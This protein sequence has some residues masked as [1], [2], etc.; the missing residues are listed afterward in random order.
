MTTKPRSEPRREVGRAPQPG[1][2][3]PERE[4]PRD[5][6]TDAP[7]HSDQRT[8]ENPLF[9]LIGLLRGGTR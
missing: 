6:F 5:L 7:R 2:T 4:D 8:D 1:I 9:R 3:P